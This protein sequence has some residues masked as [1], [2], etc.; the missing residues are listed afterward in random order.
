MMG[1]VDV[2]AVREALRKPLAE[3]GDPQVLM[4]PTEYAQSFSG[5]V[6]EMNFTVQLTQPPG[7]DHDKAVAAAD[8]WFNQVPEA[9]HADRTLGDTVSDVAVRSCSGHRLFATGP[10]KPPVLG[11]EWKVRVQL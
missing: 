9:L 7:T 3:L 10:D 11:A 4:A 1:D 2:T 8:Q 6:E 5:Q